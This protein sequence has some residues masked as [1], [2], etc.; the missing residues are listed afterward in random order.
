AQSYIGGMATAKDLHHDIESRSF[1]PAYLFQGED[2]FRKNEALALFLN[3]AVEPATRDFNLEIRRGS[4]LDAE[5]LGSL[6]AM[7]PMLAERDA[8]WALALLPKVMEQPKSSGVFITMILATQ[9]LGTGFARARLDR[10]VPPGRLRGELMNMMKEGGAF[11]GRAWGE[12]VDAW[13]RT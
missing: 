2:D 3:A 10:N 1:R 11:P 5:T 13:I 9:I 12:A 6:L 8:A 4:E 7:P